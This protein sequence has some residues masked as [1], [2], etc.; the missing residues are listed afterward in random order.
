MALSRDN[1]DPL[2]IVIDWLD[3]CRSGQLDTLLDLYDE[4]ATL[5]C[6]CERVSLTGRKSIATYW[7]SKL[8]RSSAS[9]FAL[10][11]VTLTGNDVHVDY[12]GY[13][14]KPI[15]IHFRFSSL[16]K[17]IHTSCEPLVPCAV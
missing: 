9:A 8:E 17:I 4:Q 16:G 13:E 3:A 11:D 14:G 15:R 12:R 2:G 7:K 6:D 5:V 1:F 10:D